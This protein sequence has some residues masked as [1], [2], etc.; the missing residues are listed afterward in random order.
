MA[1]VAPFP[2][3]HAK[4]GAGR[5]NEG[6]ILAAAGAPEITTATAATLSHFKRIPTPNNR[7]KRRRR[8]RSRRTGGVAMRAT[9]GGDQAARGRGFGPSRDPSAL[10]V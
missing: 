7:G 10:S 5:G 3:E 9:P 4:Q 6:G 2:S 8:W 1:Q